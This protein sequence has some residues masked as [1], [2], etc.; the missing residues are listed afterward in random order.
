MDFTPEEGNFYQ[1]IQDGENLYIDNSL[2]SE[3]ISRYNVNAIE[4]TIPLYI[5]ARNSNGVV[6]NY[7]NTKLKSLIINYS[8]VKMRIFIPCYSTTTVINAEGVQVPANTKGLYD[9]VEGKFYTNKN[10]TGDDFIAGP[11]V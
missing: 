9:L 1:F 5:F 3:Y 11:E 2:K 10:S 4:G 8:N 7:S 6:D